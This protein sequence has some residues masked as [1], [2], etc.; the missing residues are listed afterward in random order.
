MRSAYELLVELNL[1]L[2]NSV[3]ILM[4]AFDIV[5][6][7]LVDLAGTRC[8]AGMR[9]FNL[10]MYQTQLACAYIRATGW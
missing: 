8:M 6:L 9:N 7:E 5:E 10:I 4:I 1:I 3:P 2:C